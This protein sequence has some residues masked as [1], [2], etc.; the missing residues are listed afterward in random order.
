MKK[1]HIVSLAALALVLGPLA[2]GHQAAAATTKDD[3]S[4]SKA[5]KPGQPRPNPFLAADKY[6][7]THFDPAQTDVMPYA[8]PRGT[9]NIDLRKAARVPG[10]PISIMTLATPSPRY[11]WAAST[12][13]IA[14]VDTSGGGWREVARLADPAAKPLPQGLLDKVLAE[15]LTDLAQ[16]EKA[17]KDELGLDRAR[18]SANVYVVSGKDGVLYATNR[19]AIRAYGLVDPKNPAAGI[20]LLRTMDLKDRLTKLEGAGGV[21]LNMTYD[22]KLV[23]AAAQSIRI[24]DRDL[25][26]VLGEFKFPEGEVVSNA[27]AVDDKNGIY[28][29]SDKTMYKFAWT[30]SKL[31]SDAADGAWSSPYDFGDAMPSVKFGK[32]TGSTPTLMGFG[33]DPD[34]LVVITDGSNRMKLVA[35][36]RDQVP[37][38]FQQRPGTRSNRIADQIQVTCGLPADTPFIQSE[39]S[40]VG[41][42][43]GAFVVNNIRPKG[44]EDRLVDVFAGG[45][46][47]EPA[48]G[49]ERFEWDTK[50]KKWQSVWTRNDVVSTSMVPTVSGPSKMVF[51][52]GYT[53]ADGWEVTGMDW[54]TGKTVHRSIFGQDNLGNGAYALIQA[55]PNG[56]LLF[57]SIGGPTRVKYNAAK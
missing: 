27:M 36:W 4:K 57:N 22:G 1:R 15:P 30:G 14:Y 10:G 47:L 39:Q 48:V 7:L 29:A 13:G 9:F 53:K 33:D 5:A 16:V 51:V 40:V 28:I 25:K 43:Y 19:S 31:S 37:A 26:T 12:G 35:F 44:V 2:A 41:M 56:D 38:G 23:V 21:M 46:A 49:A 45:P 24:V 32:G 54:N 6:A 17:V 8:M 18:I 50:A 42:G 55:F 34:K 3:T 52:N 20:K 11:M